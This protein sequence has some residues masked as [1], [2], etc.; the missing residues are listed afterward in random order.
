MKNRSNQP[1]S[2]TLSFDSAEMARRGRI[3]AYR[4]HA[5]HDS[6]EVTA[7][8]RLAFLDRFEHE[9]DPEGVL[10]LEERPRRAAYARKAHFARLSRLSA[11]ARSQ[12]CQAAAGATDGMDEKAGAH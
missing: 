2:L 11:I 6:R 12:K 3:G 10:P 8:A 7:A 5:T 9:V 1:I 4:L